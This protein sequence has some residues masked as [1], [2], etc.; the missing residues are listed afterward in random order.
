MNTGRPPHRLVLGAFLALASCAAT[1]APGELRALSEGEMS[2]VYGQGLSAPTLAAF[3][4]LSNTEQGNSAIS[5]SASDATALLG[6]LTASG[7]QGVDRQLAQQ[8]LQVASTGLQ[9]TIKLAQSMSTVTQVLAPIGGLASL[10]MVGFPLL[11]M[12]PVLPS[13]PAIENKH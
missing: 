3:G 12:L 11:F 7:A 9:A 5:G 8:R 2:D 1:A 4:A 13:L 10:P 6:S